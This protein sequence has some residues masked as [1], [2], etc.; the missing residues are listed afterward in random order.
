M[1]ALVGL[2]SRALSPRR[3][4][5]LTVSS[6]ERGVR[7]AALDGDSRVPSAAMHRAALLLV[8]M[9]LLPVVS[10]AAAAD[11]LAELVARFEREKPQDSATR[12]ATVGEIAAVGTLDA[13]RFLERIPRDDRLAVVR[14]NAIYSIARLALPDAADALLRLYRDG[15]R[16]RRDVV[17]TAWSGLR[18]EHLPPAIVADALGRTEP[19]PRSD[20]LNYLSRRDDPRLLREIRR[21]VKDF[22]ASAPSTM[23]YLMAHPSP[24]SAG[25][26]LGIYDDENSYHRE[27]VPRLFA[28]A[29]AEIRAVLVE[30]IVAGREPPLRTAG[31]IASRAK[32]AEAEEPLVAA[33]RSAKSNELRAACLEFAAGIGLVSDSGRRLAL[34]F[35]KSGPEELVVAGARALRAHPTADAIA[36]LLSLLSAR[37]ETVRVEARKTLVLTTGQDFGERA[38]RWE[39]W[40]RDN[41]AT[42]DRAREPEVSGVIDRAFVD[43]ALAKG[44]AALRADAWIEGSGPGKAPWD[45]GGHP[46]GTTALVLLALHAAGADPNETV[47]A[48][49]FRWLLDQ[50][51]PRATYDASILAMTLETVGRKRFQEKCAEIAKLLQE[52][53]N[54]AGIWGYPS[55]D[56]DHSNSQYAVLGLR[57]AARAGVAVPARAWQAIRDHFLATQRVDGGWSYVPQSQTHP[58]TASMTAVGLSC[59]LIALENGDPADPRR[60][61]TLSALDRGFKTLGSLANLEKDGLYALYAMERA[62]ML[63]NRSTFGGVP[64]YVPGAKR[65]LA[66]QRRDGFWIGDYHRTVDTAFAILFLKKATPPIS[67]ATTGGDGVDPRPGGGL[68]D[69]PSSG[70]PAT[71]R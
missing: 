70:G 45:C 65:L 28:G 56:G 46:V 53:R 35:L 23:P 20:V 31:T 57:H 71:P 37:S 42:F 19:S 50:P 13:L 41:A 8:A 3:P 64:W 14:A 25:L 12:C 6:S 47:F 15:D 22:P 69:K 9:A 59:L 55:G 63:G 27:A 58:T 16:T 1:D 32:L 33:A 7:W 43:L 34:E 38:D 48:K 60:G 52:M 51:V 61:E 21:F 4:A 29:P 66:E 17:L 26:M 30:A 2:R 5:G 44:A 40:W 36:T 49:A 10:P 68:G 62:G 67:G 54:A 11:R 39:T 24:E 18:T